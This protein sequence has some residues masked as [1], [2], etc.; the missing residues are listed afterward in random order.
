MSEIRNIKHNGYNIFS[1]FA[2]AG[3]SSLGYRM[4][5]F[6]VL[7]VNEFVEAA[8]DSYRA[9]A[10]PYTIINSKDIRKL[11]GQEIIDETG[12]AKGEIDLLDG[13]P[14]CAS[15]SMN[16]NREVDWGKVKTYSDKGQRT[17]DLFFEFIRIINEIQPKTFVAENVSGLVAGKAKGYFLEILQAFKE[18]GYKVEARLLDAK[19]LGVPQSRRR[20]IFV[21]VRKDLL[22]P[23]AFP[24]PFPYQYTV[25]DALE[26]TTGLKMPEPETSMSGYAIEKEAVKLKMN[27]RSEKYFNLS[28]AAD[29]MP[30]RTICAAW[31]H[32]GVASVYHPTAF[33]KF[34]ISEVKRLCSFP[35]D[36]ELTGDYKKQWERMGRA[37]PPFMMKAIAEPIRDKI[38]KKL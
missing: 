23:P 18:S 19:W 17:D 30:V 33:R 36:F 1:L 4:A 31:G 5:G 38:L 37:V 28:R 21:G 7:W 27:E 6:K 26:D 16:G 32:G 11:S 10:R 35:D 14:P 24:K 2:G 22:L 15:F 13:S 20:L 3:G 34:S 25:K 8:R 29:Y 12:I 9:N